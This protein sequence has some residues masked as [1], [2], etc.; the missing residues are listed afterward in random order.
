MVAHLEEG[1][2]VHVKSS[3]GKASLGKERLTVQ[4][5]QWDSQSDAGLALLGARGPMVRDEG[6]VG[7]PRSHRLGDSKLALVF[8]S[9]R[10]WLVNE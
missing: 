2:W 3:G 5:R 8:I 4:M 1:L 9:A 6:W 10:N 7:W